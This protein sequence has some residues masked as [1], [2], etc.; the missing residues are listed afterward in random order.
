MITNVSI[1]ILS[2]LC[3]AYLGL[4]AYAALWANDLIFPAPPS[5]YQEDGTV[6]R[7]QAHDGET[8]FAYYL[9][10]EASKRLL[11]YSHG[12]GED[13]GDARPFLQQ[14]S[15]QGVSALAYEYPGYGTSTGKPSEHGCYAAIEAAFQYATHTLG[16]EP[17]Q[18]TLYGRSLGS[19]PSSWLA[20]RQA[21]AG[22]IFDGAFT[23]AFR[24]LTEV[25]LLPWDKFDN[26]AR[27]PRIKCPVLL[28]HG[29]ADRTVP[30]SHALKNW[31]ILP[32]SKH[33]LF[34]DGAHHGNVI[35]I[36]GREYWDV[37]LPFAKG[38]LK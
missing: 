29:T 19:G 4:N 17:G 25:K 1:I 23:S 24:V 21:V 22:L 26:Y 11:I 28:I 30:F 9:P 18:I 3:I 15:R 6:F 13:I 33:K 20:E 10:A 2:T 37:V 7:L 27:L 5:S 31:Q 32:G 14:F 38:D 34:V 36:A 8:I 35:D 12:N 16:Y